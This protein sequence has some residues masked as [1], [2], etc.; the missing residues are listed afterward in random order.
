MKTFHVTLRDNREMFIEAQSYRR[1]G[2]QYVFDG[3]ASGEV[4][5]VVAVDVIAITV[6]S[7]PPDV[8]GRGWGAR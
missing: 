1:E 6:Y 7:P 2:E 8:P 3:T 4:E 5:F